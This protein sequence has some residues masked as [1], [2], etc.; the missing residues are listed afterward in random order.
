MSIESMVKGWTGEVKTK[1]SQILFL[2]MKEYHIFNNVL[3]NAGSWTTQIDH[4]IVSRYGVFVVETKN[5]DGWIYGEAND[6]Y[7]TQVFPNKKKFTFQN[8][9]K[10]NIA[11]TLGLA[12]RLNISNTKMHSVIVFWGNCR[13]KKV[14][15]ENVLNNNRA[16]YIKSKTQILLN[17]G[18]IEKICQQLQHIKE[19]TSPQDN[20]RHVETL[21]KRFNN[22]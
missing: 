20:R 8:P 14:M 10:Q 21:K 16:G 5:R 18:E 7:W 9:L 3:I 22:G 2:D 11:H 6:R 17:D 4:V 19:N 15:P 1:L 13:F 12:K